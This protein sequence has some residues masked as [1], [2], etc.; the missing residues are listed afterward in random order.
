MCVA[1]G[2]SVVWLV[3]LKYLDRVRQGRRPSQ[4]EVQEERLQDAVEADPAPGGV[5]GGGPRAGGEPLH[6]EAEADDGAG[7]VL[8]EGLPQKAAARPD[9]GLDRL[10]TGH[11]GLWARRSGLPG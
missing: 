4:I 8:V 11:A 9:D 1:N 10:Q 6:L 5:V 2:Q 3:S 7:D